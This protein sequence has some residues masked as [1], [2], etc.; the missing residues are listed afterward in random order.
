M[1]SPRGTT[2]VPRNFATMIGTGLVMVSLVL[3][4]VV[5]GVSTDM[6]VSTAE[7]AG[8]ECVI[9]A[10]LGQ[11]KPCMLAGGEMAAC[12][13][14]ALG[15]GSFV[16]DQVANAAAVTNCE[17][18]T[19]SKIKNCPPVVKEMKNGLL[20]FQSGAD[21]PV[22]S[23]NLFTCTVKP[24]DDDA[25]APVKKPADADTPRPECA[26]CTEDSC[27]T[28]AVKTQ[29]DAGKCPCVKPRPE[30][31]PCTE[32]SCET[33]AV[34]T[35]CDAGKCPCVKTAPA[36][37]RLLRL[38][39]ADVVAPRQPLSLLELADGSGVA[40]RRL[41]QLPDPKDECA[42]MTAKTLAKMDPD[43]GCTGTIAAQF[44]VFT[45]TLLIGLAFLGMAL[46]QLMFPTVGRYMPKLAYV[47]LTST[48]VGLG[49]YL[50]TAMEK[51]NHAL[52]AIGVETKGG[53]GPGGIMAI[54]GW[55]LG[56]VGAILYSVGDARNDHAHSHY[57]TMAGR[58]GGGRGGGR[59]NGNKEGVRMNKQRNKNWSSHNKK[60]WFEN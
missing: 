48:I 58:G 53:L 42:K 19:L 11:I 46:A 13:G 30:C 9:G 47:A 17:A 57:N 28:P 29:C 22:E 15:C 18:E 21:L 41:L 49:A 52:F 4:A 43:I 7:V 38:F 39:N 35:Q 20:R 26:P 40:A 2:V 51:K 50:I 32:K 59:G 12:A 8:C 14:K 23:F 60:E 56:I 37:R 45:G 27:K 6:L 36:K 44:F 16:K 1:F 24:D 3:M 55:L 25:A 10:V 33:P 5:L 34:K 31:A 54:I